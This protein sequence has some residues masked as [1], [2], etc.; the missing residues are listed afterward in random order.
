[1]NNEL[2]TTD[3]GKT[4]VERLGKLAYEGQILDGDLIQIIELCGDFLNIKTRTQYSKECGISYNAAKRF[5]KNVVI[6]GVNFV[7]GE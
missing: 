2:K 3:L 4:C 7:V 1:M 6:F 5:R